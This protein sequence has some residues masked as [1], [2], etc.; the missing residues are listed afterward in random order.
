MYVTDVGFER[1]SRAYSPRKRYGL[2]SSNIAEAMNS[3]IKECRELH[4]TRVIDYIRG[5]LHLWFH[6]RRTSVG[7]LKLTLTTKANVNIGVKGKKARYLRVYPITYYSFLVKD[8]DLDETVDLT[9]KTC[10][11]R[12]FDIDEI[13]CEHALACIRPEAADKTVRTTKEATRPLFV[14]E[15]GHESSFREGRRR[16]GGSLSTT[17][18]FRFADIGM[19]GLA[20]AKAVAE[21]GK[22]HVIMAC[23][24]FLKAER[25]AKS[26]GITKE[27]ATIMHLDLSS[28]DSVRQ[29][30]DT[31]KRSGRPL[32]ILVCNAAV[33]QPTAKEPSY[34]AEGFELSVG[35]N[36]LGHFL[37]S[38][39]LLNDLNQS[40][41]PSK[42]LIIVGSITWNTNTLAGNVPLKANLGDLRGLVGGLN[43]L[44]TSSMIDGAKAY[45]DSKVCNMLTMQEF[46][47]RYHE[48]TGIT[49]SSLYP[50][51]IATTGLFREHIPLFRLLFPPFQKYITK[52]YV[53]EDE[54]GKRLGCGRTKLDQIGCLLSWNKDLASFEDQ[55]SEEASDE[56]KARKM[57]EISEKLVGLA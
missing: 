45:K 24:D 2:M 48:E 53:S 28:L 36:H 29:F 13:P 20:T 38:W 4:I 21:T 49:F 34:T 56:K 18:G 25:A 9:S 23:R 16:R 26:A 1:W 40:D 32:D 6:D 31:F 42:R 17:S 50:G 51:C 52:R 5:V 22:W 35:T 12:E 43:G 54:T 19:G 39:L 3:A 7:K 14:Q 44:N 11:C 10:T 41:Y 37:L 47:R 27:N 30:V 15:D 8:G 46:H 57:W 33:Y 55:L